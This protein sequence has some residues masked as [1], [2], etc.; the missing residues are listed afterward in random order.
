MSRIEIE[1]ESVV[2]YL[3]FTSQSQ[4]YP[5]ESITA[6]L[7]SHHPNVRHNRIATHN[8]L[9]LTTMEPPSISAIFLVVFDQRV[10]YVSNF[11]QSIRSTELLT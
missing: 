4:I 9:S 6:I 11:P 1:I 8:L 10:G 5:A 7:V 3:L 2:V